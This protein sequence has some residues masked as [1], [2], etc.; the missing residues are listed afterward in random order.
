MG[1]ESAVGWGKG[2][3]WAE[4]EYARVCRACAHVLYRDRKGV[5]ARE[6]ASLSSVR[7]EAQELS[8]HKPQWLATGCDGSAGRRAM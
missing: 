2:P 8:R 4:E 5:R 7:L 3:R 1:W 6:C